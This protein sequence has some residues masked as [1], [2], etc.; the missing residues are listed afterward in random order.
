MLWPRRLLY[1]IALLL[2]ASPLL[3]SSRLARPLPPDAV[4]ERAGLTLGA[5]PRHRVI[6]TSLRAGGPA[7]RSGIA[8]GDE[9]REIAGRRVSGL[10]MSRQLLEDPARCDLLIDVA[11]QGQ[12]HLASLQQ[13]DK[14]GE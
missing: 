13:C 14:T 12:L 3:L 6:V 8:V 4:T 9:L 7:D 10:A 1:A 2:A 11:R 5:D